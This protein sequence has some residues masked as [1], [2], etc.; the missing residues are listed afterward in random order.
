MHW[1]PLPDP[2][3]GCA[4]ISGVDFYAAIG[5]HFAFPELV[6]AERPT[7]EGHITGDAQV[8]CSNSNQGRRTPMQKILIIAYLGRDPELKYTPQGAVIAQF[9]VASSEQW[10]DKNGELQER[11][12]WFF[13]KAFGRRAE[14][15]GEYLHKGSRVYLEGRKG[16]EF[17]DDKKTGSKNYRDL[18][19]VDRIE[20]LD[21]RIN[22][23]GESMR[24]ES[25]RE[26]NTSSE[27]AP[28]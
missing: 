14:I 17:W 10:K 12:E 27:D 21:S 3:R 26:H 2:A 1:Q 4:V 28:F 20:F 18:V 9:S 8:V 16:T 15:A 19:Y 23:N 5:M 7:G 24:D 6:I 25:A 11:T 13:V 22:G